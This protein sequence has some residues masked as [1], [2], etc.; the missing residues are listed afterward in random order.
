MPP[1]M[2]L[3]HRSG[4]GVTGRTV[5]N[6][7]GRWWMVRIYTHTRIAAA[8]QRFC[9]ANVQTNLEATTTTILKY[10]TYLHNNNQDAPGPQAQKDPNR[11]K[12]NKSLCSTRSFAALSSRTI[13]TALR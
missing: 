1:S 12:R 3:L 6:L 4:D 9:L 5:A 7:V 13:T 11:P 8:Q 2:F 10:L